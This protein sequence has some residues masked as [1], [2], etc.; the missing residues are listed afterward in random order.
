MTRVYIHYLNYL[1]TMNNRYNLVAIQYYSLF[2][3]WLSGKS[4]R[5]GFGRTMVQ[6]HPRQFRFVVRQFV[7]A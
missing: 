7:S 1:S 5:I 3:E 4:V 6:I 2:V